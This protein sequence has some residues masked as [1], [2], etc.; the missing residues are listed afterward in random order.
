MD[1]QKLTILKM[2]VSNIFVTFYQVTES[3]NRH[4]SILNNISY[5]ITLENVIETTFQFRKTSI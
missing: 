5:P 1:Q 3:N 4:I 2:N